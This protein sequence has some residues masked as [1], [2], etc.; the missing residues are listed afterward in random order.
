VLVF[1][2]INCLAR[3][4]A[5]EAKRTSR[6]RKKVEELSEEYGCFFFIGAFFWN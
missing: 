4:T 3:L 1:K 2:T 5:E 6:R